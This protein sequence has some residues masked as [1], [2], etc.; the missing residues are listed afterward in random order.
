[1]KITLIRGNE[2]VE[3]EGSDELIRQSICYQ[4]SFEGRVAA[5][6]EGFYGKPVA[7]A[8]PAEMKSPT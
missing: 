8:M 7:P 6:L 5:V 4:K 1:M 3:I 2:R